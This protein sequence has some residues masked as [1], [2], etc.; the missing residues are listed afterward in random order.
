MTALQL[1]I[2]DSPRK[3]PARKDL[4]VATPATQLPTAA[5][6][7]SDPG[8]AIVERF[9]NDPT[10]SAERVNQ[11]FDFYLRMRDEAARK[12]YIEAKAAF[13]ANAPK[14]Y[15]DKQNAQ[16]KSSYASIGNL[17]WTVSEALSKYGLDTSWDFD[18]TN[19]IKVSCTLRHTL[20]HSETVSLAGQPDTSGAKNPLQ[21]IKSTLTYLKIATFEGV[22]GIVTQEGSADDDGNSAGGDGPISEEQLADLIALAD[23]VGADKQKFCKF[24]QIESFA[25]IRTSQL[26]AARKAI[27]A[28]RKP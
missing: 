24:Y 23:E 14:V 6:P 16:Y 8:L 4:T 7:A 25:E 19:G 22:T 26:A 20:G 2:E 15:K 17:V 13:K 3:K 9:L 27:E 10:V 5:M 1:D 11:A 28:K 12:A 21:Q 18:Q